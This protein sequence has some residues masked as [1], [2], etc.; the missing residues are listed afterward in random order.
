[1]IQ[2][3]FVDAREGKQ[4]TIKFL[5]DEMG[6]NPSFF[7]SEHLRLAYQVFQK[8][9]IDSAQHGI[10]FGL[11]EVFTTLEVEYRTNGHETNATKLVGQWREKVGGLESL[12]GSPKSAAQVLMTAGVKKAVLKEIPDLRERIRKTQT[13]DQ[14]ADELAGFGYFLLGLAESTNDETVSLTSALEEAQ[15]KQSVST[16]YR[17][18]DKEVLWNRFTNSGGFALGSLIIWMA[19][20]GHGKTSVA[21]SLAARQA[22]AGKPTIFLTAEES[23]ASVALRVCSAVSGLPAHAFLSPSNDAEREAKET[24]SEIANKYIYAYEFSSLADIETKIRRHK[25]QFGKNSP[26]LVIL[27]H[28]SALDSGAGNWSRDLEQVAKSLKQL[29]MR[30]NVCLLVFSQVP[31]EMETDLRKRNMT[32]RADARGSRGIRMWADCVVVS[33]RHNGK[34]MYGEYDP[35]FSHATVIQRQKNRYDQARPVWGVFEFDPVLSII[36]DEML[37]DSYPTKSEF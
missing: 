28:I 15:F 36:T 22:L 34:D 16:G 18:M 11:P 25:T 37:L 9:Y 35:R 33:C 5:T 31:E 29:A 30:Q 8:L 27:D 23:T 1:V 24:A 4:D 20:S 21:T 6:L 32:H 2:H 13:R 10:I 19:P 26:M 3:L 17:W 14:L 7:D 12:V